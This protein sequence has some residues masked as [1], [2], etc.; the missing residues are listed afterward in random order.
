MSGYSRFLRELILRANKKFRQEDDSETET[1][2][3]KRAQKISPC[4]GL[5][6]TTRDLHDKGKL[7]AEVGKQELES[8]C[9]AQ[10]KRRW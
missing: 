3:S 6:S 2:G 5:R 10:T 7:R 8:P 4:C 9:R 1:K